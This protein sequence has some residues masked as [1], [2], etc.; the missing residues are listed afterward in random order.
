MKRW[1]MS[2]LQVYARGLIEVGHCVCDRDEHP[3]AAVG[4]WNTT[5]GVKD[6]FRIALLSFVEVGPEVPECDRLIDLPL[7]EACQ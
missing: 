2:Y 1:F 5:H 6:G 3:V 4:R 7:E